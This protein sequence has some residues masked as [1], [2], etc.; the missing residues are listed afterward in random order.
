[1]KRK[2][3]PKKLSL[4]KITIAKLDNREI[5]GVK[6]G[7]MDLIFIAVTLTFSECI[8]TEFEGGRCADTRP[9]VCTDMC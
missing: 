6:G 2:H 3:T 9:D 5:A 8:C 1:M 7:F 4:N